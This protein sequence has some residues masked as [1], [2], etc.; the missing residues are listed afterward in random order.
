MIEVLQ[1]V[2][3]YETTVQVP[4]DLNILLGTPPLII[5]HKYEEW[6]GCPSSP[7]NRVYQA[8]PLTIRFERSGGMQAAFHF[9]G[10]VIEF[11]YG[12]PKRV[13]ERIGLLTETTCTKPVEKNSYVR[14]VIQFVVNQYIFFV[15]SEGQKCLEYLFSILDISLH[16]FS[17]L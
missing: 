13:F 6:F 1:R 8:S 15:E 2:S 14:S 4:K 10:L 5:L 3:Q 17:L 16:L 12:V 7:A 11:K 9:G